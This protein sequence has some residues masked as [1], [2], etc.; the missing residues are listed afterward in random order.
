MGSLYAFGRGVQAKLNGGGVY[1]AMASKFDIAVKLPRDK[2][3]AP[4]VRMYDDDQD[5]YTPWVEAPVEFRGQP[6][7]TIFAAALLQSQA[8]Q[9]MTEVAKSVAYAVYLGEASFDIHA[10]SPAQAK[11]LVDQAWLD[12]ATTYTCHAP[13]R[14][15][16]M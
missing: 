6:A 16:R 14:A 5:E 7:A 13:A 1:W 8:L 11:A 3:Q 12:L 10:V 9:E 2:T 15:R 4:R